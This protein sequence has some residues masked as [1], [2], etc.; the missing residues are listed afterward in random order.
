MLRFVLSGVLVATLWFGAASGVFAQTRGAPQSG[1]A[2]ADVWLNDAVHSEKNQD[3]FGRYVA[4]PLSGLFGGFLLAAPPF[5]GLHPASTAAFMTGGALMLTAATGLW[6]KSDPAAA[7]RWF[8]R[9]GSLGFVGLGVGLM[10]AGAS[11]DFPDERFSFVVGATTA[12][13]F[14]SQFLLSVLMTPESP[15]TL[16]LSLRNA[17]PEARHDRVL[18]FLKLRAKQQRIATCVLAP[19]SM[20]L[21][22]GTM[23]VSSDAATSGGRGFLLGL[24]IGVVALTTVSV[25]YELAHTPDW[26]RFQAGESP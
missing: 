19:W 14:L 6:A 21:G 17:D 20:A 13:S 1:T 7:Q 3:G 16:Q 23:V 12:G 2:L 25:I 15:G 9:W 18:D 5:A 22:V 26:Q 8:S 11:H 10:I 24:G 4:A